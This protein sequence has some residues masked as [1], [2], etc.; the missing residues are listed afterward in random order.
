[1]DVKGQFFVK[2]VLYTKILCFLLLCLSFTT[3][4]QN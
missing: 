4:N 3:I 1:M 2:Y